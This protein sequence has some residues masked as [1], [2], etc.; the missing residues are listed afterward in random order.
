MKWLIFGAFQGNGIRGKFIIIKGEFDE[1][2]FQ[3]WIRLGWWGTIIEEAS[4]S[5]D[6]RIKW[7]VTVTSVRSTCAL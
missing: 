6:V 5:K 1:L 3:G 4:N 7:S 2:N